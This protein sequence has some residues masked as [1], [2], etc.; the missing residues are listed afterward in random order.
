M[1][2]QKIIFLILLTFLS[3][4]IFSKNID[5]EFTMECID[6]EK[7]LNKYAKSKNNICVINSANQSECKEI[8]SS[9]DSNLIYV[10]EFQNKIVASSF[11]FNFSVDGN[12]NFLFIG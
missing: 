8:S 4:K 5:Y 6:I 12:N 3:N 1:K 9:D 11:N 10:T 7:K 2:F